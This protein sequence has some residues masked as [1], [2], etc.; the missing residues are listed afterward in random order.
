MSCS[1]TIVFAREFTLCITPSPG[2][3]PDIEW[4]FTTLFLRVT[5]NL[6]TR[7]MKTLGKPRNPGTALGRTTTTTKYLDGNF[8][9]TLRRLIGA[10]HFGF[11]SCVN[12]SRFSVSVD[13]KRCLLQPIEFISQPALFNF[14]SPI[15]KQPFYTSLQLVVGETRSRV[16]PTYWDVPLAWST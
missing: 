12:D 10:Y 7:E 15:Q 6:S 8:L 1:H 11:S 3:G 16:L 5:A 14:I 4:Y 13:A 9:P 2:W